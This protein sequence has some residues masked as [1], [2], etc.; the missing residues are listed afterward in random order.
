MFSEL[1]WIFIP[2]VG[3]FINIFIQVVSFRFTKLSLL[4]SLYFGFAVGFS[5]V[6]IAQ[7]FFYHGSSSNF[8]ALFIVNLITYLLLTYCFFHFVNLGETARRVRILRELRD[9]REGMSMEEI[10]QRYNAEVIFDKRVRRLLSNGQIA[11][12]NEKYYI[13]NST[14]LF[15]TRIIILLKIVVLGKSS[16][17]A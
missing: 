4:K 10:L 8:I 13:R 15:I 14:M 16:E 7:F 3:L 17:F 6:V 1:F 12:E 5:A 2:F 9:F 11:L